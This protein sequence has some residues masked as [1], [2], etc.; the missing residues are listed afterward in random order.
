MAPFRLG[1]DEYQHELP[2][3]LMQNGPVTK[4]WRQ[5]LFQEDIEQL[6]SLGF[7]I[8]RFDCLTWTDE[9]STRDALVRGLHMPDSTGSNFNALAD[10]LT[11]IEVPDE[12]GLVLALDNFTEGERNEALLS[13]FASASR[14]W[15]LFGR[16]FFVILRT[17]D[18]SYRGPVTL[19]AMATNW[20]GREWLNSKRGL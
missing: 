20:N 5:E 1:H 19:G 17:D 13:L 8:A 3:R 15:L 2:W 9:I 14:Y 7:D 11:D 16:L 18:P 4:Y 6:Q 10:S 12:G